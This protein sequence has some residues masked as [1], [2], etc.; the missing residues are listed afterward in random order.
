M[1]VCGIKK[2]FTWMKLITEQAT[3]TNFKSKI[4]SKPTSSQTSIPTEV[5]CSLLRTEVRGQ[6]T[7]SHAMPTIFDTHGQAEI[8]E[9]SIDG[10]MAELS[11]QARAGNGHCTSVCG[12]EKI[13][14]T[15]TVH[16]LHLIPQ[17]QIQDV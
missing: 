2:T 6:P 14:S 12:M 1:Y 16:T 3:Q 5:L 15:P 8:K 10:A 4:K 7:H 13:L 11:R 17:V 9:L